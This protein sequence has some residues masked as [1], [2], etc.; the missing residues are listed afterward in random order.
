[1]SAASDQPPVATGPVLLCYDGS[2]DARAAIAAAGEMLG[3]SRAEVLVVAEPIPIWSP[4]DPGAV[5]SATVSKLASRALGLEE[6]G[7]EVARETLEEGLRLAE[8]AGF[9]ARG[10]TGR[11]KPW[12]VICEVAAEIGAD[13]IVLGAC[14]LGRV[15][16]ALLG[17]VSAAVVTHAHRPVLVVPL[18]SAP[19]PAGPG[20]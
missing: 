12:R 13:P 15:Q 17:S 8:A 1:M 10:R 7:A 11:G 2:E 19:A 5:L 14:G 6:V 20:A 18:H 9:T 4:S 16:S 3:R